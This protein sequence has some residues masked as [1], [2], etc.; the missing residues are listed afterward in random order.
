MY[1]HTHISSVMM[2]VCMHVYMYM[3]TYIHS[4]HTHTHKHTQTYTY[5][6]Q[7]R[8]GAHVCMHVYTQTYAYILQSPGGTLGR[9]MPLIVEECMRIAEDRLRRL[10]ATH[11]PH[12]AAGGG[13][14]A[15]SG[16]SHV[17]LGANEAL[18]VV[19]YTYDLNMHSDED[20]DDNLFVVLNDTLRKR[21]GPTMRMLKPY[22]TYLMRGL[23]ALP[24]VH[25]T[26][27]RG[28]PPDCLPLVQAKYTQG[29][30]VHWSA[31]TSCALQLHTAKQFA[32]K[33]GGVVFRIK[34]LSARCLPGPPASVY[35]CI[36]ACMHVYVYASS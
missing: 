16:A 11:A 34:I 24:E 32:Q 8:W 26:C 6:L 21:S 20:G 2:A 5:I 12:G 18:A 3:Y 29:S 25:T 31:F 30:D 28:V 17:I 14:G 33:Q 13:G 4:T 23:Q 1:T 10:A 22:L 15:G 7:S 35:A 36:C 19:S 27:Y 9:K